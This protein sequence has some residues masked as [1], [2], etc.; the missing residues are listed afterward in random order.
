[1]FHQLF[2]PAAYCSDN[3]KTWRTA[4]RGT[5]FGVNAGLHKRIKTT[6]S[7]STQKQASHTKQQRTYASEP[8]PMCH[9][10]IKWPV[11]DMTYNVFSGTLN[12]TQSMSH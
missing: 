10:A 6:V 12:P 3:Q 11:P 4:P 5:G 1:M 9:V 2:S 7:G 8:R